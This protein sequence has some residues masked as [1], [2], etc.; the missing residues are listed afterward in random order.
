MT[1]RSQDPKTTQVL[2]LMKKSVVCLVLLFI[3]GHIY[4]IIEA[5]RGQMIPQT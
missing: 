4:I 5:V 2:W 1:R 3:W